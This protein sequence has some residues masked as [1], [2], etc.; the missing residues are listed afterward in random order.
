[1]GAAAAAAVTAE[2]TRQFNG[3]IMCS[4]RVEFVILK[5]DEYHKSKNDQ[6]KWTADNDNDTHLKSN[7]ARYYE[8]SLLEGVHGSS[9]VDSLCLF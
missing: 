1:M 2:Q 8:V 9:L 6:M 4:R 3:N 5:R 7:T